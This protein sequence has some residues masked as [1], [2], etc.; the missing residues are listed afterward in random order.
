MKVVLIEQD[1]HIFVVDVGQLCS[2]Q[3]LNVSTSFKLLQLHALAFISLVVVAMRFSL[4]LASPLDERLPFPLALL[5]KIHDDLPTVR[6]QNV[7][8]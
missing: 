7:R 4:L 2:N 1:V 6:L 3:A 8:L 5:L